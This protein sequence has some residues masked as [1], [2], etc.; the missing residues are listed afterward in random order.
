MKLLFQ[1][2]E[3]KQFHDLGVIDTCKG[4]IH[5]PIDDGFE[6]WIHDELSKPTTP[7]INQTDELLRAYG[8][9]HII[10]KPVED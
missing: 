5:Q 7:E 2:Y 6:D 8:G 4:E 1:M 3:N 10:A 9:P